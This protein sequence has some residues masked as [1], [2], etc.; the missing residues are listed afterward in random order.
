LLADSASLTTQNNAQQY[1]TIGFKPSAP[2]PSDFFRGNLSFSYFAEPDNEPVFGCVN[3][4]KTAENFYNWPA[5]PVVFAGLSGSGY[6][7]T[8]SLKAS[9]NE[10]LKASASFLLFAAPTGQISNTQ[11]SRTI[12]YSGVAN[13][14][15][16]SLVPGDIRVN[17]FDFS[18]SFRVDWEVLYTVGVV[19][20]LQIKM[21]GAQESFTFVGDVYRS[22]LLTGEGIEAS[23]S[24]ITGVSFLNWNL[25][26]KIVFP[27]SGAIIKST[28]TDASV[29]DII[30]M[31]YVAERI[32]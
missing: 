20:P 6:L 28:Q 14:V 9:P 21:A 19:T 7:D 17:I 30:R 4:L 29:D 10:P 8:Y 12:S 16:L 22:A 11:V 26:S 32:Y 1:P 24:G 25:S 23:L 15:N 2:V 18:Y 27:I 3:Y 13:G 5:T 31:S